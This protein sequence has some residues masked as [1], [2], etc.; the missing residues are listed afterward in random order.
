MRLIGFAVRFGT[1]YCKRERG[2]ILEAYYIGD[3]LK[4]ARQNKNLT[5]EELAEKIDSSSKSIWQLEGNKRSTTIKTLLRICYALDVP[6]SYFLEDYISFSKN[7]ESE[8]IGLLELLSR[9]SDK[10][11]SVVEDII[12]TT[13]NNRKDYREI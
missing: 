10:E 11:L 9:M 13:I 4:A 2:G 5:A 8:Y 12:S 6:L 3:K 7:P 1:L